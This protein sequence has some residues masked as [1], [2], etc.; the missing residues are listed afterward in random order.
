[1]VDNKKKPYSFPKITI[2]KII[3]PKVN[4]SVIKIPKISVPQLE[5]FKRIDEN[6]R[7]LRKLRG[8]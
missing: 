2:P 3:V 1:M 8:F 6:L 4:P 7:K 5:A